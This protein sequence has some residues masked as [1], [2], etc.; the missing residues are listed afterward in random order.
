M[1][2]LVD[3]LVERQVPVASADTGGLTSRHFLRRSACGAAN[4]FV[5]IQN[6]GS[7]FSNGCDARI[8]EDHPCLAVSASPAGICAT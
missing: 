7:S 2:E 6:P 4:D 5:R 3:R 1:R 8:I